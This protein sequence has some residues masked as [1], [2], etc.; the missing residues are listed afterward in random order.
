MTTEIETEFDSRIG[1]ENCDVLGCNA[2]STCIVG[3]GQG[4]PSCDLHARGADY[5]F[6]SS[7]K[8]V[9]KDPYRADPGM[10]EAKP[11]NTVDAPKSR[12]PHIARNR[13]E[14]RARMRETA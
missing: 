14:R 10:Y 1:T 8:V 3:C 9:T 7:E 11:Y 12:Y 2:V 6:P 13:A 4:H 5:V